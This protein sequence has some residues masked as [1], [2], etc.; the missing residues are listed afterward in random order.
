MLATVGNVAG[1]VVGL[2]P[3]IRELVEQDDELRL[4]HLLERAV[5]LTNGHAAPPAAELVAESR[6]VSA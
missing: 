1:G 4:R 3:L 2:I 6:A 5:G